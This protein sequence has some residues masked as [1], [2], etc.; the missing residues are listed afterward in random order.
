MPDSKRII[1]IND[2][3]G[4]I[5]IRDVKTSK[6][7]HTLKAGDPIYY[8]SFSK[9]GRRLL[10]AGIN[11]Q[12]KLWDANSGMLLRVF[13]DDQKTYTSIAL[14]PDGKFG[15]A[16]YQ[17]VFPVQGKNAAAKLWNIETGK[18]IQA[19]GRDDAV[20]PL[21]FSPDGK[22]AMIEKVEVV[23][24][25]PLD[26]VELRSLPTGKEIK[27]LNVIPSKTPNVPG[28]SQ[29]QIG[30]DAASISE[31]GKKLI[32]VHSTKLLALWDLDTGKELWCVDTGDLFRRF[33]LDGQLVVMGGS[34]WDGRTGKC[35]WTIGPN[36]PDPADKRE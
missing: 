21:G 28:S 1:V 4:A 25:K 33:S 24:G 22:L 8:F 29:L 34:I 13:D 17:R 35:L 32:T 9:D 11:G 18:V 5:E 26:F 6:V 15:F 30:L 23:D 7:Q 3:K 27:R 31:D 36:Y 20:K 2:G 12:M 10:T 19:Y 14:S 16:S